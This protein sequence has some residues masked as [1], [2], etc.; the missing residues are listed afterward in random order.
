MK[1]LIFSLTQILIAIIHIRKW[2]KDNY[3][4]LKVLNPTMPLMFRTA[5]NAM[6]AVTTELDFQTD[7]LLKFMIQTGK[8]Q[9]ENGTVAD[10]RVDQSGRR[11]V[12]R[13]PEPEVEAMTLSKARPALRW[14]SPCVIPA[15][16]CAPRLDEQSEESAE[17]RRGPAGRSPRA[18]R[19]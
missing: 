15:R 11:P 7:D 3:D 9:N 6:P 10:D 18:G 2:Y 16:R 13:C 8:F 17:S 5:E 4:E 12:A 1:S 19:G 14:S